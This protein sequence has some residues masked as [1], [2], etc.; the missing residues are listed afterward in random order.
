MK[1]FENFTFEDKFKIWIHY[2]ASVSFLNHDLLEIDIHKFTENHFGK[3]YRK[4]IKYPILLPNKIFVD[5]KT[6]IKTRSFESFIG[7]T[8]D[9][10]SHGLLG[11]YWRF[12]K[13]IKIH[14]YEKRI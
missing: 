10:N 6:K 4:L 5:C 12:K 1:E 8:D 7:D 2:V 3:D 11:Y 13:Q 9:M 14:N